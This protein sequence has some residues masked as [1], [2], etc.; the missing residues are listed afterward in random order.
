ML[1]YLPMWWCIGTNPLGAVIKVSSVSIVETFD[2]SHWHELCHVDGDGAD[3][4]EA[5]DASLHRGG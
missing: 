3:D 4:P 2:H 5:A 1:S